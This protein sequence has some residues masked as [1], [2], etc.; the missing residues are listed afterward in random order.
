[1]KQ[2]LRMSVHVFACLIAMMMAFTTAA[3]AQIVDIFVPNSSFEISDVNGVAATE[4]GD[5]DVGSS[6]QIPGWSFV[7]QSVFDGAAGLAGSLELNSASFPNGLG[8]SSGSRYAFLNVVTGTPATITSGDLGTI[9]GGGTYT[10]TVA[11]GNIAGDSG[12]DYRG[13]GTV[14]LNLLA[15]GVV[16]SSTS[17][18]D[19]QVT[20]GAFLDFSTTLTAAESE[21]LAG[22][23]LSIQLEAFEGPH[24]TQPGFDNVRLTAEDVPEPSTWA[25]M[26]GGLGLL[27]FA[28][29]RRAIRG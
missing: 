24:F 18:S 20:D 11:V 22:Q 8:S 5:F 7:N 10:L 3:Q 9:V 23:T 17:V 19:S 29:R 1:M 25:T 28:M 21:A 6:N 12:Q 14:S 4:T 26:L 16:A 27:V 2:I 13:L 15:N